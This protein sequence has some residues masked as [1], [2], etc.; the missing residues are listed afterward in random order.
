MDW[1]RRLIGGLRLRRREAILAE[2]LEEL[3]V[4]TRALQPVQRPDA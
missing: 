4:S 3:L 1:W 2:E